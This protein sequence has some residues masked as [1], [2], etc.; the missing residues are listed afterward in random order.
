MLTVYALFGD[1]IRL[2]FFVKESDDVFMTLNVITLVFFALELILSSIGIQNYF[3]GFFFWL[4]LISTIS[5]ITDIEPVWNSLIGIDDESLDSLEH[6]GSHRGAKMSSRAGRMAR[7]VRLFR[8]IRI[9]KLYKQTI[10]AIEN[11]A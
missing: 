3:G 1:D 11:E 10:Q 2:L 9:V 6:K 5:I 8:L 7:I 4:D